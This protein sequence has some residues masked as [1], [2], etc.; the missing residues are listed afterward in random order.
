MQIYREFFRIL[1]DHSVRYLVTGGITVNLYGIPRATADIDLV[2]KLDS[3]NITRFVSAAREIGL[4]PRAR[5]REVQMD[6]G[7]DGVFP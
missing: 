6:R 1:N 5:S 4:V 7:A 2:V 3:E